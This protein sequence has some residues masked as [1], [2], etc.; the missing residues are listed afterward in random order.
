MH[1]RIWT[2]AALTA[3]LLVAAAALTG[4]AFGRAGGS[5]DAQ[6]RAA[7]ACTAGMTKFAGVSARVFCG[8]AT[9]TVHDGSKAFT[10]KGGNC[11]RTAQAI[12]VNI[13]EVVLGAVNKPKPEYFG[14]VLGRSPA[15]TGPAAAHD[16]TYHSA[17]VAVV[18]AGKSYPLRANATAI[19]KGGRSRGTFTATGLLGGTVSGSFTC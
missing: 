7:S 15:A 14:F 10:I 13:G 18:H 1:A 5:A 6:V 12:A 17:V 3:G 11:E 8:P 9:A 19:L 2:V 16:G 4:A